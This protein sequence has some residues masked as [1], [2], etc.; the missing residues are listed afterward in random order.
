MEYPICSI[1][2]SPDNGESKKASENITVVAPIY[3]PRFSGRAL[4]IETV[5]MKG[6]LIKKF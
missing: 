1:I 3:L 5:L 2:G 6:K 4:F